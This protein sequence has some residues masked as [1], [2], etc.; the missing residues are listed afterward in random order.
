MLAAGLAVAAYGTFFNMPWRMLPIP[1]PIRI[2]MVAHSSHGLLL[3]LEFGLPLSSLA[4]CQIVG[5][6][7]A[8]IAS[9]L[10]YPFAAFAFASVVSMAPGVFLF[11]GAAAIT[12]SGDAAAPQL[13]ISAVANVASALMIV[14]AM[15]T[16]VIVPKVILGSLSA[17]AWSRALL[18]GTRGRGKRLDGPV[19]PRDRHNDGRGPSGGTA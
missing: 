12:A 13:L 4:A 18:A 6:L 2:G 3:S 16:G 1:I 15:T 11:D 7:V 10:S 19:S 5:S 9:R 14:L 17:G 8:P